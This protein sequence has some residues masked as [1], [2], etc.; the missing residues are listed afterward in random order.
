MEIA[1]DLENVIAHVNPLSLEYSDVLTEEHFQSWDFEDDRTFAHF[2]DITHEIWDTH[3]DQIPPTEDDIGEKVDELKEYGHVDLVTNR[4]GVDDR[5]EQWLAMNDISVRNVHANPQGTKK[6]AMD[7]DVY[8]DDNPNMAG[9]VD[10]L[11]LYDQPW[12]QTERGSGLYLYHSYEDSYIE[13]EGTAPM[14]LGNLPWVI[15]VES[16]DDVL[17]D[18]EQRF[19]G[20]EVY[21]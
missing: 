6:S 15:R 7:Y 14:E 9:E 13:S 8:I 18:L 3:W 4:D 17:T 21:A 20:E 19:V 1:L 10:L 16:L 5:I 11:Y 2:M 12:N